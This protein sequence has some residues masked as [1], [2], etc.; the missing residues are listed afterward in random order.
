MKPA[1]ILTR[2]SWLLNFSFKWEL[3][4]NHFHSKFSSASHASHSMGS[5]GSPVHI[6]AEERHTVLKVVE[7][8]LIGHFCRVISEQSW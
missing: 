8:C 7:V 1:I 3:S 2:S 6:D 5:V 4:S